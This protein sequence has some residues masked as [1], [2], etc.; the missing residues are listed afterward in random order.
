[1][2]R[3]SPENIW[4]AAGDAWLTSF[5]NYLSLNRHLSDHSLR[6]YRRDIQDF[7][8]WAQP[9]QALTA[10]D[11]Q[12]ASAY[13]HYLGLKQL[14]KA[15][16][17]RKVSALKTW[18][19]YLMREGH[20]EALPLGFSA[21]RKPQRLPRFI[22]PEQVTHILKYLDTLGPERTSPDK[23]ITLRNA[24]VVA[25]LFSSGIRVAELVGLNVGD[26]DFDTRTLRVTGKG[27]RERIAFMSQEACD[28][29]RRWLKEWPMVWAGKPRNQ[30][31]DDDP[32]FLNYQGVRIE[33][34]SVHRMLVQLGNTLQ[35]PLTPHVFR[36]SFATHLLNQGVDLRMVQ[37]LLGHVSIRS[38]QIYT[39]VSTER[40]RQAYLSAHPLAN[41]SA[42]LPVP[43]ETENSENF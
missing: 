36:H 11:P 2:E 3:K 4:C 24:A 8:L 15:S 1:M 38:T 20:Q 37:A 42:G 13:L 33:T 31:M 12:D 43:Q 23:P 7:L 32:I 14:S 34:R 25:L 21:A 5:L 10:F 9:Q 16:V 6:A 22:V 17:A 35:L 41:E 26:V 27:N 40:L 39:H 29:L 28:R 19:K 30:P 18:F